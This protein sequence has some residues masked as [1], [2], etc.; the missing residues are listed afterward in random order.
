MKF[1]F[2]GAEGGRGGEERNKETIENNLFEYVKF[3]EKLKK[4]KKFK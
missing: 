2:W 4:K 1:F 3:Y